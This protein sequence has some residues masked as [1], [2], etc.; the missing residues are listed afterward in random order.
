MQTAVFRRATLA[1]A[2][3]AVAVSAGDAQALTQYDAK[4][5][6]KL[7]TA[8]YYT[9]EGTSNFYGSSIRLPGPEVRR[10][11]AYS[12]NQTVVVTRRLYKTHPTNWGELYN[13]WRQVAKKSTSAV[14]RPGYKRTWS[15]WNVAADPFFNYRVDYTVSYYRADGSFLSSISTDYRHTGDYAC[16][17]GNCSVLAGRDGRAS[18]LLTY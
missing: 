5:P 3:F 13:N 16:N 8:V 15:D 17:G 4:N 9:V 1:V 10:S 12:G 14:L 11:K 7:G 2:A 6:S 18:L